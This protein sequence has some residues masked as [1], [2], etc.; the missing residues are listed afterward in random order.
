MSLGHN[1]FWLI[2]MFTCL[3][4]VQ[5]CTIGWKMENSAGQLFDFVNF[6]VEHGCFCPDLNGKQDLVGTYHCSWCNFSCMALGWWLGVDLVLVVDFYGNSAF[7]ALVVFMQ[8]REVIEI[9]W[10]W[11][12][13]VFMCVI[14]CIALGWW[15]GVNLVQWWSWAETVHLV[16]SAKGSDRV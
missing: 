16:C 15:L 5:T 2:W 14:W 12:M 7:S 13:N 3:N 4:A 11:H 6:T 9:E 10:F 1:L 8:W